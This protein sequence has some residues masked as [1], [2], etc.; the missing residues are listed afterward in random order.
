MMV[1]VLVKLWSEGGGRWLTVEDCGPYEPGNLR[2]G[3]PKTAEAWLRFG[4][5]MARNEGA[6]GSE[7]D[8]GVR[9][10]LEIREWGP[11]HKVQEVAFTVEEDG[12]WVK[13]AA[14]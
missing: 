3:A 1:R 4:N 13:A 8:V 12:T 7:L 5:E 10:L 9:H 2:N 11:N 14:G 6:G